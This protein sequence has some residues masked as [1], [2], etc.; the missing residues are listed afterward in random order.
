MAN[1]HA[2]FQCCVKIKTEVIGG[3]KHAK[4]LLAFMNK[5]DFNKTTLAQIS[6]IIYLNRWE[7]SSG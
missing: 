2:T 6:T 3:I 4:K 7:F 5:T 1:R